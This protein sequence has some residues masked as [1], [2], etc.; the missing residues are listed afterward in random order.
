MKLTGHYIVCGAGQVGRVV[1]EELRRRDVPHVIID[2]NHEIIEALEEEFPHSHVLFG[3]ATHDEV[4]VRAG[5]KQAAGLVVAL[6]SDADN[7]YVC[8]AAR[9]MNS[10]CRIVTRAEHEEN[11]PR[12]AKAGADNVICPSRTGAR[13]MVAMIFQ[14]GLTSFLDAMTQIGGTQLLIEEFSITEESPLSG[15]SLAESQIPQKTGLI[16]IAIRKP[17]EKDFVF[18]PSGTTR[19]APGDQIVV[20]GEAPQIDRLGDLVG[21]RT[22]ESK[23]L[24][25]PAN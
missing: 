22:S 16:V 25:R 11:R 9:E 23:R 18:N 1:L 12:I 20:L 21:I 10:T 8:L 15:C 7:L 17:L 14:P 3:D 6:S 4:L 5:I 13:R 19:I 24:N 2:I